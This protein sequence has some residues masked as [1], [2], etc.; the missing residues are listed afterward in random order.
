MI[1]E[2]EG[3]FEYE[4]EEV[5]IRYFAKVK[6]S[7]FYTDLENHE[8]AQEDEWRGLGPEEIHD[9]MIELVT[10]GYF[11]EVVSSHETVDLDVEQYGRLNWILRP[12]LPEK[13]CDSSGLSAFTLS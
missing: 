13:S 8:A 2:D 3:V 11:E 9:C 12:C 6:M 4:Y 10:F 5:Y 1:R 7:P